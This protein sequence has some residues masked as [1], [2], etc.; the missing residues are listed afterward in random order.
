MFAKKGGLTK[1]DEQFLK[2]CREVTQAT[3]GSLVTAVKEVMK[4]RNSNGT[5]G[6]VNSGKKTSL[7]RGEWE[8]IINN[9][10]PMKQRDNRLLVRL[11]ILN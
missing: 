7:N 5:P 9:A 1:E 11:K 2:E 10:R 6:T 4:G 3:W 8:K